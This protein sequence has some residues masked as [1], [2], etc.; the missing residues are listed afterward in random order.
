MLDF[1]IAIYSEGAHRWLSLQPDRWSPRFWHV[2]IYCNIS[3]IL[4]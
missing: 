1:S 2:H 4:T 3:H